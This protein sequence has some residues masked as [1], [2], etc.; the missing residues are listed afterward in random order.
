VW[1]HHPRYRRAVKDLAD[2]LLQREFRFRAL[3]PVC[4]LCGGFDSARRHTIRRYLS[5]NR[6]ALH[7]FYAEDVWARISA[8]PNLSA[9]QMENYVAQ[10]SDVVAIIVESPGTFT[11]L[12]AFSMSDELRHKLLL[13]LDERFKGEASFVSTGPV[14]WTDQDSLFKPSV[15]ADFAA[16]LLAMPEIEE[17]L[18]RIPGLGQVKLDDVAKSAKHSL[19]LLCDL[20]AITAP[21]TVESLT[22]LAGETFMQGSTDALARIPTH[23]ELARA[24]HHVESK[25]ISGIEYFYR[26]DATRPPFSS[27]KRLSLRGARARFV[28]ALL[29]LPDARAVLAQL[30]GTP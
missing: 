26:P 3:P 18:D 7:V 30:V 15:H 10:V 25:K 12:G 22:E 27:S 21:A 28:S 17:R 19:Y 1:I 8:L 23:L 6:P 16:I 5:K 4:F 11:E 14:R 9:M 29:A 13:I 24:M 20:V 2:T